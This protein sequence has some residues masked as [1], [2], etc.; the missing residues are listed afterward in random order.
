MTEAQLSDTDQPWETRTPEEKHRPKGRFQFTATTLAAR[1]GVRPSQVNEM[2]IDL[3]YQI[4]NPNKEKGVYLKFVP[5]EKGAKHCKELKRTESTGRET[6]WLRWSQE[7]ADALEAHVGPPVQ[8]RL[9][10]LESRCFHLEQQVLDLRSDLNAALV[11]LAQL[12]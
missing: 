7:V 5:T 9:E 10:R 6:R 3:G 4:L 2:L 8:V 12:G 1:L 11:R